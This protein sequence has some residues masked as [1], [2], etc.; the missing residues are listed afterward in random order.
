[1]LDKLK[2]KSLEDSI[3]NIALATFCFSGTSFFGVLNEA[4]AGDSSTLFSKS[5]LDFFS[6]IIFA[7]IAGISI[8]L[9]TFFQIVT[10]A[11]IYLISFLA[12]DVIVKNAFEN[13]MSVGAVLTLTISLKILKV[14]KLKPINMLPAFM[15]VVIFSI[16]GL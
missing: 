5:V 8:S 10:F 1:M 4:F 3:L 9:V 11:V 7:S 16:V 6:S 13:F 12:G 15:L 2:I 14:I